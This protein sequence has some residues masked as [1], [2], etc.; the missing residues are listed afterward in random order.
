MAPKKQ[1]TKKQAPPPVEDHSDSSDSETEVEEEVEV[2]KAPRQKKA[3]KK[4]AASLADILAVLRE[5][6]KNAC[7]KAADMLEKYLEEE[8]APKKKRATS[9]YQKFIGKKMSELKAA[10]EAGNLMKRAVEI[11]NE[12]KAAGKKL[13]S[14]GE[15]EEDDE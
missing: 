6:K 7:A 13:N 1:V 4:S 2:A 11:Y 10:G 12:G 5:G 14:D 15:W 3:P 9:G 8:A